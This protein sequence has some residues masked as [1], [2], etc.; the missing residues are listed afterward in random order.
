MAFLLIGISSSTWNGAPLPLPLSGEPFGLAGCSL[1][2]SI[3]VAAAVHT[4]TTGNNAGYAFVD[5]PLPIAAGAPQLTLN[6]QWLVMDP[7]GTG[8]AAMSNGLTWGH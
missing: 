6:G 3:E 1:Y 4:G 7:S 8:P 2:T 5:L